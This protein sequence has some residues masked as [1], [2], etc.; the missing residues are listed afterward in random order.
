MLMVF[1][2]WPGSFWSTPVTGPGDFTNG[3]IWAGPD[4]KVKTY[5]LF[6][7]NPA[8][9]EYHWHGLQLLWG[10]A[11][12]LAGVALLAIALWLGFRLRNKPAAPEPAPA[13]S[14]SVDSSVP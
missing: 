4:S 12:I 14:V 5:T 1:A 11:Y 8:Y 13:P 2:P 3:L 10:N 9:K 6:G 7:D